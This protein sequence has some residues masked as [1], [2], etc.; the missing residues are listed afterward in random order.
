MFAPLIVAFFVFIKPVIILLYSD[1]FLLIEG[2][3]YW[4]VG[5]TLMQAMGWAVSYT[6]LA[7]AKPY[8]FFLNEV[9]ASCYTVPLRLVGYATYGLTGFGI[10]TLIGYSIYLVQVLIITRQ[11][12]TFNYSGSIWR[13]FFLLN[14]PV[15]LTAL[16]K[17]YLPTV[18]GY[19]VGSLV[20]IA[21]T[22]YM[23]RQLN[24]KMGLKSIICNRL[25]RA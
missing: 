10:A 19:I 4:A 16:L 20:L 6:L 3:M 22:L 12:F 1:K 5:A 15:V 8:Q 14:I 2:M 21:T 7:K 25:K 11:L 17:N 18:W 13:L 23:L 24:Q 9:L